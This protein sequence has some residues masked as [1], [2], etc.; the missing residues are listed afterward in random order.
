MILQI[1]SAYGMINSQGTPQKYRWF[2]VFLGSGWRG[3][4][5]APHIYGWDHE[6]ELIH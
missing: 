3:V 1:S 5:L 2:L 4:F 6:F